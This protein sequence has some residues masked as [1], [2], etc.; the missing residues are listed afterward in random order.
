MISA[1]ARRGD[2]PAG[3]V[4]AVALHLAGLLLLGGFSA[5]TP[6]SLVPPRATRVAVRL[7]ASPPPAVAAQPRPAAPAVTSRPRPPAA[8]PAPREPDWS[9]LAPP[10]PAATPRVAPVPVAQP[11]VPSFVAA[12]LAAVP[13]VEV[14]SPATQ[15]PEARIDAEARDG[16]FDV[17]PRPRQT[18]RPVYPLEAR[19]RGESGRV[20]AVVH[21][22]DAGRVARVEIA[23][24]SGHA[25]LDRAARA[26]LL[27]AR[28][29]PARRGA[30][31]VPARVRLTIIFQLI[32]PG[33]D[34]EV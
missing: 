3:L 28:F 6:P 25:A 29:D 21:V 1:L 17:A 20:V 19:Q 33:R 32:R 31:A 11:P 5:G 23:E 16:D 24:G 30:A 15:L 10:L 13:S 22:T 8:L 12:K 34:Q 14:A 18:I 9:R 4:L 27:A 7:K 2:L 26:A